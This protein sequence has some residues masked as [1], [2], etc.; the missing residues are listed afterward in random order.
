MKDLPTKAAW[1]AIQTKSRHEKMVSRRLEH[2]GYEQFLPTYH[3]RR[4]WSDRFK[5][6]EL[7]LF[8]SY[9]FCRLDANNPARVIS[10]PGTIRIVGGGAAPIPVADEEIDA[11]QRAVSVRRQLEPWPYLRQGQRVRIESGPMTGIEGVLQALRG[12]RRLI[13]SV[14]VLQRSVAVDIDRDAVW[15]ID[16]SGG[17]APLDLDTDEGVAAARRAR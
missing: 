9:L 2:M 12:R 10:A 11:L 4:R 3:A 14:T 16:R 5:V 13:V 8:E 1:F 15:P 6:V 7:P 17:W